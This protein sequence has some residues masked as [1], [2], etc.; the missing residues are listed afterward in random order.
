MKA[1]TLKPPVDKI[2]KKERKKGR[3]R[4]NLVGFDDSS[5]VVMAVC[6][7]ME[8]DKHEIAAKVPRCARELVSVLV[9]AP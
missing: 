1:L 4:A 9:A 7:T 8:E 6:V 5:Q 2:K 3:R